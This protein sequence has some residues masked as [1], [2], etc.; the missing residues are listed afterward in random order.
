MPCSALPPCHNPD[1]GFSDGLALGLGTMGD[2]LGRNAPHLYKLAWGVVFFWDG[3]AASLEEQALG[4]I[5][6]PVEIE[7]PSAP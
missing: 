2:R 1:L 4:P 7:R 6:N 5:Q 3:R